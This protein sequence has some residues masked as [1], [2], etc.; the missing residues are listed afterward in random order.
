MGVGR[1]QF[2]ASGCYRVLASKGGSCG[3]SK[4]TVLEMELPL[5]AP[6]HQHHHGPPRSPVFGSSSSPIHF[7]CR[8]NCVAEAAFPMSRN[9]AGG[10]GCRGVF[11]FF[12]K[13]LPGCLPTICA[14]SGAVSE[15]AEK[16]SRGI[17]VS[18]IKRLI[19][20]K[21]SNEVQNLS[22]MEKR[23]SYDKE[24]PTLKVMNI[25]ASY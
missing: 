25:P 5:G 6:W 16:A 15:G 3:L 1:G 10:S 22:V 18:G 9:P 13:C 14:S 8:T 24:S 20:L 11:A 17:M 4:N 7:P 2:Q 19:K 12:P 23:K 21:Y